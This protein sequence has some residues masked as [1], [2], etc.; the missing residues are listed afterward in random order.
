MKLT[1]IA[2]G[3]RGDVQP[4]VALGWSLA[5]RGH[6][7]TV[8]A[9]TNM[10]AFV[11]KAGLRHAL[12]PVDVQALFARETAQRM[13]ADGRIQAFF[14]WLAQEE[15]AYKAEL[16]EALRNASAGADALLVHPLVED[17]AAALGAAQ[18][19][20]VVPL[21]FFPIPPSR[22]F[23]SPF[24][25]VRNLGPL[26]GFTHALLLNM[27]W[28]LSRDDVVVFRR[29]LGLAPASASYAREVR[30]RGLL[31]L[32]SYS[33]RLFPR[34][35]D[36]AEHYVQ[37][38]SF[39]MPD[40]LKL[41]LGERG[42]PADL[43]AWL[44]QGTP[45]ICFGFGSMPILDPPKMLETVRSALRALGARGVI[46]AGWSDLVGMKDAE[47]CVT[48]SVDHAAL[49]E[50]CVAAVH[51]GGSGTTY[52]SVRGGLPTLIASV[53]A[54][55]PLWGA[56]CRV[57]GVGHTLSFS[58]LSARTLTHGLRSI[59]AN[60]VRERAK[61]LGSSLRTEAGLEE[62]ATIVEQRVPSLPPPE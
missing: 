52:A 9:P 51:H 20:P 14:K 44:A 27:L 34:P 45:P 47:L 33:P 25:T 5:R 1:L 54:D 62:A 29:E 46:V 6:D 60:D 18:K 17:R 48:G 3:T 58:K 36:W 43:E 57:L 15:L 32:L 24:I 7:V 16:R 19:I 59:L 26:N 37:S 12:L 10:E 21:Y 40:E 31:T 23:A 53:F 50:R 39:V 2:Y 35:D 49:F 61:A 55:Q 30:R 41:A 11:R 13:L 56:R 28:K 22:R 42:L 8:A 4:F 38:S